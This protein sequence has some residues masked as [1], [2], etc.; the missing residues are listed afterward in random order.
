MSGINNILKLK[1]MDIIKQNVNGA[2]YFIYNARKLNDIITEVWNFISAFKEIGGMIHARV[3]SIDTA[4]KLAKIFNLEDY[5]NLTTMKRDGNDE[6][7]LVITIPIGIKI[8]SMENYTQNKFLK[9]LDKYEVE[10]E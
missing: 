8:T 5:V 2:D 1:T 6:Y 7:V 3:G 9:R 4:L 10:H